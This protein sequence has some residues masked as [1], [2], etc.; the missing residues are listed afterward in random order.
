MTYIKQFSTIRFMDLLHTNG[1]PVSEWN[2]T[3]PS[4]FHTQATEKGISYDLVSKLIRRTGRNAWINVPHKASDDFVT[5]LANYLKDN[6]PTKRIIYVEYSNEVWNTFF[7]Q[8]KY[9][10]AQA[11]ALGLPNYHKFYAQRSLQI[12][13]I[14]SSVFGNNSP[15]LKFVIS[16][17]SVSKWVAD[18]IL[19]YT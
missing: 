15:R 5:K 16:Y 8:G 6:I 14:F 10:T 4:D 11:T 9:A 17:Q 7:E 19:T 13:N 18:Q 2:E 12:F 3:T 1:N